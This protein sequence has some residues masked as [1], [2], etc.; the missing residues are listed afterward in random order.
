MQFPGLKTTTWLFTSL[1][2]ANVTPARGDQS[3]VFADSTAVEEMV[4]SG[5]AS[6]RT[7][8][9]ESQ[10]GAPQVI[11]HNPGS[12]ADLGAVLPSVRVATNSRGE[13]TL[14]I[15]GAPERHVQ[16][17]L[18]GIPLNLPW[19]E[20][21]DL[22]TIPITGVGR[23]LGRRGLPSLLDGPGA[24]AGTVRI[25][26]PVLMGKDRSARMNLS[27]GS[28]AQVRANLTE[29]RRFGPWNLLAA[30]GWQSRDAFPLPDGGN[31]RFNSDLDQLS[32]L[33]R[34]SRPVAG[35]GRLNLLAS[36]WGGSKGVPPE[37]HL[38]Q[39]ARF[40]RYPVRSRA[41]VGGS[42]ALPVGHWDLNAMTAI[43]FY[44]QEIDA[45]GPDGWD[46][47]LVNGQDYEKD[48]DRTG[49]L[50]AG[51]TRWLD[52]FGRLSLQTNVRYTQH[53]ESLSV[54]GGVNSYSQVLGGVVMEGEFFAGAGWVLR[55]GGGMDFA[56]T[57]EAGDKNQADGFTAPALN[58]R[59]SHPVGSRAEFHAGASRRSR[60]P[61]LRELYSGALG[62]FVPNPDLLPEQ[63]DLF[64]VGMNLEGAT[65]QLTG[66]AF[67]QYLTDGIERI[68]LPGPERQFM[69]VNLTT[70]RVP[71]LELHGHWNPAP[72]WNLFGQ[73]TILA[74]RVETAGGFDRPAE[75]RPD[76]LSR[77]GVQWRQKTGPA[78]MLEVA[79]TGAR[80]SADA[81][82]EDTGL[83]RLPAHA[84]WNGRLSWVWDVGRRGNNLPVDLESFARVE[85]IFDQ[86][87]DYQVG[88][89]EPG[90]IFSLG[91]S[92]G[93]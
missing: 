79:V 6:A 30:G 72:G 89:P 24:L 27:V 38:G 33:L 41:L 64:E 18:D 73:H 47:P 3:P 32:V 34:G 1:I 77:L 93:Y 10:V 84:R 4:V 82:S 22:E 9:S 76:Y 2:F 56:S 39:D 92:L 51:A 63:Q 13:S 90:R 74:A 16:T 57:P 45:R 52:S 46:Q 40:W 50:A 5:Q 35:R 31:P 80:W 87:A 61:S 15:R 86:R 26:P 53:R 91:A 17:F 55:T 68:S 25:L 42:L 12:L 23:L 60:F 78:A 29:Q 85:N 83:T 37:L 49:H 75:D 69:R 11:V 8:G 67:L 36:L 81:T 14:M 19:D 70:I 20:R 62:R 43:D 21:V 48:F 65:W 58:L 66:A 7:R 71:G 88:L 44:R 54:G 28:E 59:L